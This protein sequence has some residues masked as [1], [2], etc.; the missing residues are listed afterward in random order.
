M[1]SAGSIQLREGRRCGL[2]PLWVNLCQHG[3]P[4]H[5]FPDAAPVTVGSYHQLKLTTPCSVPEVFHS[6]CSNPSTPS[7]PGSGAGLGFSPR[8]PFQQRSGVAAKSYLGTG[9]GYEKCKEASGDPVGSSERGY[10]GVT[11]VRDSMRSTWAA[12]SPGQGPSS[13]GQEGSGVLGTMGYSG[14]AGDHVSLHPCWSKAP[15][16]GTEQRCFAVAF[17]KKR[18]KFCTWFFGTHLPHPS[19]PPSHFSALLLLRQCYSRS[20]GWLPA[21]VIT[22]CLLV[23]EQ[24]ICS[25]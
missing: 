14:H 8:V 24:D 11:A 1:N 10:G 19:L 2:K 5:C 18:V 23:F 21:Q 7:S 22:R 16:R 20:P 4:W 13:A 3:S 9:T 17:L 25:P 12:A 6:D 15:A